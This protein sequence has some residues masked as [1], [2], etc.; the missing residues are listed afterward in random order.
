MIVH[1]YYEEDTRVRSEAEALVAAGIPVHV[2][3]LR[4]DGDPATVVISGV[5]VHHLDVQRHQGA[6]LRVYLREYLS[7]FTRAAWRAVRLHRHQRFGLVQVHSLPDFLVFAA[8]PLR[9]AGVP[10]LLDLHEAMPEFFLSRFAGGHGV[11]HRLLL[12]QERLSIG[13]SSATLTVNEA[14][15]DRLVA[16]GVA[17]TKVTVVANSPSLSRFDREAHPRRAF[18]EDGSVRLV[19]TGALTP[20]YELDVAIRAV[21]TLAARHP[22]LDAR[23]DLYGRGDSEA[24]LRALADR[25]AIGDRV[26]FHG[27]IPIE[28]VPSVVAAGDIGLAPTRRDRF[29]EL[30]LSTKVLEYAAMAKPV[31]ASRLPLVER[32]FPAGAVALYE[33]GEPDSLAAAIVRLVDDADSREAAVRRAS[34]IVEGLSWERTAA[35]YL[36]VVAR[37]SLA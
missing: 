36:S 7:F 10:I 2:L 8:M 29:T 9:L 11:L 27:R 30:S 17:P 33:T 31:V 12:V 25:L 1:A 22:E 13:V 21:A 32:T 4:R 5:E 14:L 6:R 24:A 15:R 35:S 16:I 37:L 34:A 26:A 3:G 20:T 19:Y 18:R 28:Q 23:L